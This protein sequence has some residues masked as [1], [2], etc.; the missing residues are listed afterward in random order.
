MVIEDYVDPNPEEHDC[1]S[2]QFR[3]IMDNLR[4]LAENKPSLP[5]PN[6]DVGYIQGDVWGVTQSAFEKMTK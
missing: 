5:Q 2:E 1:E 4:A 6:L 3:Y